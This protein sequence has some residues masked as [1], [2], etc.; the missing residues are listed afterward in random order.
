[1]NLDEIFNLWKD[2]VKIDDTELAEE[3]LKIP[4]LHHKYYRIYSEERLKLAKLKA[5][6]KKLKLD[7]IEFY[8]Y[9]PT[10]DSPKDWELPAHGRVL[11]NDLQQYLDAD[12][13]MIEFS[14]RVSYQEEKVDVLESIIKNINTRGFQIKNAVD[15][16]RWTSGQ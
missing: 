14:L 6:F 11:K 3:S 2:D 4:L 9:G 13:D 12:K 10:E 16:L 15:F 1:M 8:S 5:D 7:K